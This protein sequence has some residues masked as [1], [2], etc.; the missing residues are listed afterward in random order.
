[1]SQTIL[2]LDIDG[3]L[4]HR[5]T[6]PVPDRPF[7][8]DPENVRCLN[9]LIAETGASIV[10]T[11]DWRRLLPWEEL[12]AVLNS[13]GIRGTFIG[14]TPLVSNDDPLSPRPPRGHE[15]DA[16]QRQQRFTGP[17]LILDDRGDLEPHLHR[18]IQTDPDFGL[19]DKHID[20]A[21]Q[22]LT[23]APNSGAKTTEAAPGPE[24]QD[25]EL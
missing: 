4:N 10:I 24:V 25:D 19:M 21:I 5:R 15:V 7:S 8:C 12:C 18:L 6:Q 9:A 20:L 17:Y 3:V 14:R 11:S 16:W 23:A 13:F 22:L 2:F 1:M